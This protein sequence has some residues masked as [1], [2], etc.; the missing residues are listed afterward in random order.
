M[1]E[2]RLGLN[3]CHVHFLL[4]T[5]RGEAI[6]GEPEGFRDCVHHNGGRGRKIHNAALQVQDK[7]YMRDSCFHCS[8][9][10][11]LPQRHRSR[12]RDRSDQSWVASMDV[13]LLKPGILPGLSTGKRKKRNIR[14]I[15]PAESRPADEW[16]TALSPVHTAPSN[17]SRTR[18]VVTVSLPVV[19]SC[20]AVGA[21]QRNNARAV[22]GA[23]AVLISD[24]HY[25]L[26]PGFPRTCLLS[27]VRLRFVS[28]ISE[29]MT[30]ANIQECRR[31]RRS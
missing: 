16:R 3:V 29:G 1:E 24:V 20:A 28:L 27:I 31:P 23:Q 6:F 13:L 9:H 21:P 11:L 14:P 15:D 18:N 4:N 7:W 19:Q 22:V 25:V 30:L 17:S 10:S 5:A 2:E 26:A 12:S 8:C